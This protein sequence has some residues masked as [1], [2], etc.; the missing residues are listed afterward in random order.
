M[1]GGFLQVTRQQLLDLQAPNGVGDHVPR[2]HG[3]PSDRGIRGL[4]R[5]AALTGVKVR[6]LTEAPFPGGQFRVHDRAGAA[7]SW[8][9]NWPPGNGASVRLRT[10]TPVRA[11]LRK[12]PR[13]PR[14]LGSP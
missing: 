6:S 10:F 13:M 7:R 5:K 9:R 4:L 14:S 8:T 11:A 1:P 12:R 3:D 2:I